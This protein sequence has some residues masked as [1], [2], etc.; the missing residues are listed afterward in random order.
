MSN[1]IDKISSIG[2]RILQE[3]KS[4]RLTKKHLYEGLGISRGTLD[5]WIYGDTKPNHEEVERM[6]KLLNIDLLSK[7]DNQA[8]VKVIG[9]DEWEELIATRIEFQKTVKELISNNQF[10]KEDVQTHTREKNKLLDH[11]STLL[12]IVNR[13]IG[14]NPTLHKT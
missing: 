10:F 9:I 1:K 2:R 14:S 8:K 13:L 3:I 5:N 6:S 11:N 4:Q 7:E 12:D